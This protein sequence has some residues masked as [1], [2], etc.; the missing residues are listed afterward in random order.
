MKA[1]IFGIGRM[2]MAIAYAM[3][4]LDF[5]VVGLDSH[6][7]AQANLDKVIINQNYT[8]Y[9]SDNLSADK[10]E[11][12][13]YEKPDIV[14]SSMPYHQNL[15][16]AKYCILNGLRYCDLGGS[17]PVSREINEFAEANEASKPIMTDLGLAPGLVN[18]VTEW[19][20]K[21]ISGTPENIK[22][23]VGGL[24]VS[25][26]N[27]PLNYICTWSTDGLINEYR[28][29]C[30]ILAGGEIKVVKG[31][32]GY[33]KTYIEWLGKKFEA[34][35]TSGGASHTISDMKERGVKNCSYKTLRYL[36]HRDIVRFL[37]RNA[38]LDDAALGQVFEKG[39]RDKTDIHDMVIL[40]SEVDKGDLKWHKEIFI[41]ADGMFSAMQ[42][43][44]AF[45][46]AAVANLMASGK[47]EGDKEQ[48]RDY[49]T[50]YPSV[51]TYKE[52]PRKE[53]TRL[54]RMLGLEI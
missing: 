16:L 47:L 26:V 6:Q 28:D 33:E 41:S 35:Y 38:E 53:L 4:K 29:D 8:F 32:S 44:T 5:D 21:E 37:I 36:G 31:M 52:I 51:L 20:C 45:P 3:K 39:C 10:A 27:H 25:E 13:S 7:S 46:I 19:G 22:M 12:L 17:V 24:P 43:A 1:A 54:L 34:F 2:G 11:I 15:S 14:I 49:Y 18:I 40:K 23:M 42:K 50:Q 48:R 9:Q 30:E